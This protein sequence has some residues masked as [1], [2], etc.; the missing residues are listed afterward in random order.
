MINALVCL[1]INTDTY[2]IIVWQSKNAVC[3]KCSPTK[4]IENSKMCTYCVFT[5]GQLNESV[6]REIK[7]MNNEGLE[8]V[9]YLSHQYHHLIQSNTRN[10]TSAS[11]STH[12]TLLKDQQNRSRNVLLPNASKQEM[13]NSIYAFIWHVYKT[14][15]SVLP[16]AVIMVIGT[17]RVL[18]AQTCLHA[19]HSLRV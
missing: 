10:T 18:V 4:N 17:N 12:H 8:A 2:N 5:L 13:F 9:Y 3:T 19:S 14:K 7:A 16:V 6:D 15:S 1:F 11:E